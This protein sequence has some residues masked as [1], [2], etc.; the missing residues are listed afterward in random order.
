V[1][2]TTDLRKWRGMLGMHGAEG[3]RFETEETGEFDDNSQIRTDQIP[4]KVESLEKG[5][6]PGA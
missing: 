4:E 6:P 1:R 2:E 3:R 5:C